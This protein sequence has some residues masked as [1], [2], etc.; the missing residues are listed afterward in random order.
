MLKRRIL[1]IAASFAVDYV[2]TIFICILC[3]A[4]AAS[5]TK[6][7]QHG[8]PA[9]LIL[10]S[11]GRTRSLL[12]SASHIMLARP[13]RSESSNPNLPGQARMSGFKPVTQPL[14]DQRKPSLRHA[15][16]CPTTASAAAT[17]AARNLSSAC[18]GAP[19]SAAPIHSTPC[20]STSDDEPPPPSK[21]QPI[22]RPRICRPFAT[23]IPKHLT[24][25]PLSPTHPHAFTPTA[26]RAPTLRP[27]LLLPPPPRRCR[28]PRACGASAT[29]A[30][31]ATS[32]SA[33]T[34]AQPVLPHIP[35]LPSQTHRPPAKSP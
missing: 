30:A 20:P 16:P 19:R 6:N 32:G 10:S 31:A 24:P 29:S 4:S 13:L 22:T 1:H 11:F 35:M 12:A 27:L 33:A 18:A 34:S 23:P 5:C 26:L 8:H 25:S 3:H 15:A 14:D 2:T 7:Y 9:S 28:P 21:V 17:L